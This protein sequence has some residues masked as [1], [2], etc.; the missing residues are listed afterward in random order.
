MGYQASRGTGELRDKRAQ[1]Q[2]PQGTME[3][4]NMRVGGGEVQKAIEKG[5]QDRGWGVRLCN[6]HD[7]ESCGAKIII[8]G[9][10]HLTA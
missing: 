6:V 5:Q 3:L 4:G 9:K 8:R 2:G 10:N 7:I 1:G